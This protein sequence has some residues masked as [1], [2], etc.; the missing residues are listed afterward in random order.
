MFRK[1]NKGAGNYYPGYTVQKMKFSF[2]VSSV[3]VIKSQ[4]T[5]DLVTFTE[6]VLN[7]KLHFLYSTWKLACFPGNISTKKYVTPT[8]KTE[9]AGTMRTI[10][11]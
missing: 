9:A 7:G 8:L 2:K 5:G 4:F 1:I 3:N 6:E 11:I 10:Y